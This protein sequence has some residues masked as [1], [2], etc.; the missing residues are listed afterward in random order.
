MQYMVVQCGIVETQNHILHQAQF[1]I[2]EK[3]HV[4]PQKLIQI[5][6]FWSSFSFFRYIL[7]FLPSIKLFSNDQ[8]IEHVF[9]ANGPHMAGPA[10]H[11]QRKKP[12]NQVNLVNWINMIEN[13][14]KQNMNYLKECCQQQ[15]KI[16][17]LETCVRA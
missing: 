14:I 10:H 12:I 17:K 5:F 3:K 1:P 13:N 2:E 11:S 15:A 4:S 7:L 9:S 8:S 16:T 6:Q